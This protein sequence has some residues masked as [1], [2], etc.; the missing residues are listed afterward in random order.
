MANQKSE[1]TSI[2][3][4][5]G[6]LNLDDEKIQISNYSDYQEKNS[7]YLGGQLKNW[8]KK[9]FENDYENI[10]QKWNDSY[11]WYDSEG[12]VYLD[13]SILGKMD[14]NYFDIKEAKWLEYDEHISLMIQNN[15]MKWKYT[16]DNGDYYV[17]EIYSTGGSSVSVVKS[18]NDYYISVFNGKNS[19]TIVFH[20]NNR[21]YDSDNTHVVISN[22]LRNL[23][24]LSVSNPTYENYDCVSITKDTATTHNFIYNN[25]SRNFNFD[26][27]NVK[28]WSKGRKVPT[29]AG[30]SVLYYN[31]EQYA[32][33]YN[34][35]IVVNN[36]SRILMTNANGVYYED[37]EGKTKYVCI[38]NDK[39][40]HYQ[41]IL[42]DRYL[43]F[44]TTSYNNTI[45]LSTGKIF[46][47]SD[48]YNDRANV[49]TSDDGSVYY[50]GTGWNEQ[51]ET[52][53][54]VYFASIFSPQAQKGNTVGTVEA[55]ITG[56]TADHNINIYAAEIAG[57]SAI[58]SESWNLTSGTVFIDYSLSG[59]SFPQG[60]VLY[61]TATTAEFID[62]YL[63]Y[64]L[65][66]E[67]GYS[68]LTQ[69]DQ[70]QNMIFGYNIL[71]YIQLSNLFV[72]QGTIYGINNQYI[73]SITIENSSISGSSVV[74]NKQDM[75]YIGAT[76]TS[77][78]FY[79]PMDKSIY[80]F[81]GDQQIQK[82]YDCNIINKIYS[83]YN[84]PAT[85]FILLSTDAG[86]LGIYNDQI[87]SLEI[88]YQ[89]YIYYTNSSYII[90][91]AEYSLYKKT[92]FEKVP[93]IL[94][95][96]FY[97]I[98]SETKSVNDCVYLRIYNE[99]NEANGKIKIWCETLNEKTAKSD[100]KIFQIT[101]DMFDSETNSMF[102]RYQP[103]FQ[104]AAG[105][106]VHIESDF[107]I[108]SMSISHRAETIQN[109]KFNL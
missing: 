70:Y 9:D 101:K 16:D 37:S 2:D 105:F 79:S 10:I 64:C 38:K 48:D 8:Y 73:S 29:V 99:N 90:D 74:C 53:H 15:F 24:D 25:T 77:A 86:I 84:N 104:E 35:S 54:D 68:F 28:G 89:G 34:N 76:P 102:I 109:A 5:K 30:F 26:L 23:S 12:N 57:G 92:G 33:S 82:A 32:I 1:I 55:Y 65:V 107:S 31:F 62:A 80:I 63:N 95:T 43:C 60:E 75:E 7:L 13:D 14:F 72:I 91:N 83:F 103:K 51:A 11:I 66:N 87:F 36:I 52:T 4:E 27:Y 19:N 96:K 3:L 56:D 100:E 50:I 78:L 108:C 17:D 94:E 59:K 39:K 98:G 20:T 93:V 6:N 41:H 18:G 106:K 85:G 21:T 49:R 40:L 81:T 22:T 42:K 97:G 58:Y 71:T 61:N 88:N 44:N 69:I 46:P 47:R 45:D 67:G